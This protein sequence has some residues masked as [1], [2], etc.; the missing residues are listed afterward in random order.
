GLTIW[1]RSTILG[2]DPLAD[3]GI[4]YF[5]VLGCL[6]GAF[7]LCRMIVASRFGR[8]LRAARQSPERVAALG[9]DPY[10]Y[11]LAAYV[12]AGMIAGLAGSLLAN[13][14]EFVSP[15]SMSWQRSGELIAMVVLGGMGTLVGPVLGAVVYLGLEEILSH[16][17]GHWRLVFGPLLVLVALYGR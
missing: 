1:G 11:Q 16:W 13:H 10:A 9:L 4:F 8:V 6:A 5:V 15:A 17:L 12:I 3:D 2:R 7:C 14:T